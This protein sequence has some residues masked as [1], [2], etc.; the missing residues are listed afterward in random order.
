MFEIDNVRSILNMMETK[1][2]AEELGQIR[3][4][5][6]YLGRFDWRALQEA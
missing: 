6:K 4:L 2:C 5:Q 3:L 1:V